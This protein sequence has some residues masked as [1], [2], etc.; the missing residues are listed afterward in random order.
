MVEDNQSESSQSAGGGG[1]FPSV[2]G[3]MSHRKHGDHEKRRNKRHAPHPVDRNPENCGQKSRPGHTKHGESQVVGHSFTALEAM[4]TGERVPQNQKES[5]PHNP[6][7]AQIIHCQRRHRHRAAY[8]EHK[9][10]YRPRKPRQTV[11]VGRSG[12]AAEA[13]ARISPAREFEKQNGK[14]DGTDKI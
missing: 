8:I 14:I 10:Q 6:G 13:Q 3:G 9:N 12:V 1:P 4:Q 7:S 11:H 2:I 5:R